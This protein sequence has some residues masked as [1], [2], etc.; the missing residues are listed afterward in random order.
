MALEQAEERHPLLP[1]CEFKVVVPTVGLG[2]TLVTN[3][4]GAAVIAK[5]RPLPSGLTGALEESRKLRVGDVLMRVNGVAV[6]AKRFDRA[7][8]MVR[9]ARRPGQIG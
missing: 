8:E 6:L 3:S 7:V 4:L 9:R 5:F 2:V 1:V